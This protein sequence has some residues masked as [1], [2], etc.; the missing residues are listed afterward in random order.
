MRLKS[1]LYKKEQTEIINNIIE[2]LDLDNENSTTLYELDNNEEKQNKIMELIP[3]IRKYF[4]YKNV[5]GIANPERCKRPYFS[6]IKFI[7]KNNYNIY[8][9]DFRV[10][11]DDKKIRTTKYIFLL[12]NT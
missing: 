8:N 3:S 5:I 2:I 4:S 7:L 12:K 1:E 6:I 9:S 11:K 10:N